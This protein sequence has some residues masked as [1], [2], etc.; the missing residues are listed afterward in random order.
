MWSLKV[1]VFLRLCTLHKVALF[2]LLLGKLNNTFT[3]AVVIES[4]IV[5]ELLLQYSSIDILLSL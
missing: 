4:E 3:F 5:I 1:K 2:A